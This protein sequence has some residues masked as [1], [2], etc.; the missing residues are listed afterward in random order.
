[1]AKDSSNKRRKA[2][3][4][5]AMGKQRTAEK[6]DSKRKDGASVRKPS[7]PTRDDWKKAPA[8]LS[9]KAPAPAPAPA[10]ATA[11]KAE[12]ALPQVGDQWVGGGNW[13]YKL[14]EGGGIEVKHHKTGD[15]IPLAA[16]HEYTSQIMDEFLD[17]LNNFTLGEKHD[18]SKYKGPR[19][20]EPTSGGEAFDA[21][22]KARAGADLDQPAPST[23]EQPQSRYKD[24][25]NRTMAAQEDKE[26]SAGQSRQAIRDPSAP[27]TSYGTSEPEP[28][29]GTSDSW[30]GTSETGVSPEGKEKINEYLL[31]QGQEYT[32]AQK[33]A[34]A[35]FVESL[36]GEVEGN[37]QPTE[38]ML[39][40][41]PGM[42]NSIVE[43]MGQFI[44]YTPGKEGSQFSAYQLKRGRAFAESL[45]S[46]EAPEPTEAPTV[47]S[48]A[49]KATEVDAA[50]FAPEPTSGGEAF[51]AD[52]KALA[53]DGG[54][55]EPA[56]ER[57]SAYKEL[58]A[59]DMADQP[60]APD[61][62]L[63][64]SGPAEPDVA[65]SGSG[66]ATGEPQFL[67]KDGLPDVGR[68]KVYDN[69]AAMLKYSR[70]VGLDIPTQ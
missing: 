26:A 47:T 1:M 44:R 8:P 50:K 67:T 37:W 7:T 31:N 10:P 3:A 5:A 2:A 66:P 53:G 6:G 52:R 9:D 57:T 55:S 30:G 12:R 68:Q 46:E 34:A 36:G 64:G 61:V 15:T 65:L 63:T 51:D 42:T 40:D 49:R 58:L 29:Y 17:P 33:K 18:K 70:D 11:P 4:Q 14:L 28:N 39:D 22:R 23:Y 27:T 59:M 38:G 62:D 35:D 45:G 41:V 13:G 69:Y 19:T 25:A 32:Y 48:A 43:K 56:P 20:S 21:D 60:P 16:D 24:I 54:T